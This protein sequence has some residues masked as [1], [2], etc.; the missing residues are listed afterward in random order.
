MERFRDRYANEDG[1]N[2]KIVYIGR[3]MIK[4][5]N[6]SVVCEKI[7]QIKDSSFCVMKECGLRWIRRLG[8]WLR[9]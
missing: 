8:E 3:Q 6:E 4:E 9:K 5:I 1:E 2:E 7:R